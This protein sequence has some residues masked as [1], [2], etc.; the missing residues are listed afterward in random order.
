MEWITGNPE[1]FII[2]LIAFLLAI[3]AWRLLE[4]QKSEAAPKTLEPPNE[5]VTTSQPSAEAVP[6]GSASDAKGHHT[7]DAHSTESAESEAALEV[8]SS[9]VAADSRIKPDLEPR[10][11]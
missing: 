1:L 5:A 10:C 8:D 3:V 11:W 9:K 4:D 6:F 7:N 2:G